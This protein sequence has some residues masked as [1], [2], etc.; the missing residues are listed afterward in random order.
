MILSP[1][2]TPTAENLEIIGDIAIALGNG[3]E[4]VFPEDALVPGL[5]PQ[6]VDESGLFAGPHEVAMSLYRS[7][8]TPPAATATLVSRATRGKYVRHSPGLS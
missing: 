6:A 8:T 5:M 3:A 1:A 4:P 7:F 2:P